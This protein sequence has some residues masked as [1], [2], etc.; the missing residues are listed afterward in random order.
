VLDN[1]KKAMLN[2]LGLEHW[3]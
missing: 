1:N 3:F 2:K